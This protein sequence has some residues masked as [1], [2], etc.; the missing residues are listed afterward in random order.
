MNG[1]NMMKEIDINEFCFN[2]FNKIGKEC[3]LVTSSYNGKTNSMT[4]SWGGVGVLWNKNIAFIVLRPQRYTKEFI[5]N[6]NTF[7]L[8]FFEDSYKSTLTYFR[9]GIW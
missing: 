3:M 6:S 1:G 5:D 2:P 8:S 4:A 7:S 9:K